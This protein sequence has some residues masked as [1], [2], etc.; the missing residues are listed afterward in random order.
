MPMKKFIFLLCCLNVV[1]AGAQEQ[2]RPAVK[3]GVIV[4]IETQTL[5]I[6]PL[7]DKAPEETAVQSGRNRLGATIGFLGEK[8]LWKGLSF[9]SGLSLSYTR[10]PVDFRPDGRSYYEFADI[11]LPLYC[12]IANQHNGGLPLRGKILFGPRLGWNLANHTNDRLQFLKE[13]IGLDLGLGVEIRFGKYKLCPE[14]VY[15]H[16]LNNLHDFTGTN[17]DYLVGRAVRDKVAFRVVVQRF[18]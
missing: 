6:E 12:S 3:W 13:R 14:A 1:P 16:G 7:D 10:N 8:K 2:R 4:G 18:K 11:E 5:G 17:Y 15:S 9:Q